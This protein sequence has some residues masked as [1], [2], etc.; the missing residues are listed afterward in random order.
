[1]RIGV[2]VGYRGMVREILHHVKAGMSDRKI[3]FCATG[4]YAGVALKGL[5]TPVDIVPDLTL[6]GLVLIRELNRS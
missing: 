2:V 4:G 5:D 6:N 1:M 3:K